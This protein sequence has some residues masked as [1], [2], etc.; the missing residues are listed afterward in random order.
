MKKLKMINFKIKS[1][2]KKYPLINFGELAQF[3]KIGSN[4]CLEIKTYLKIQIEMG[5]ICCFC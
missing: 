4:E 1:G 5:D 3:V 2:T